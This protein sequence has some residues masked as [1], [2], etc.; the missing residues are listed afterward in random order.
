MFQGGGTGQRIEKIAVKA[1]S[2]L[3][4]DEFGEF[5]F[6]RPSV[7]AD[8]AIEGLKQ[9]RVHYDRPGIQIHVVLAV[10]G[11]QL[12]KVFFTLL[13]KELAHIIIAVIEENTVLF[14]CLHMLLHGDCGGTVIIEIDLQRVKQKKH[15]PGKHKHSFRNPGRHAGHTYYKLIKQRG[16]ISVGQ[17]PWNRGKQ[18]PAGR[19]LGHSLAVSAGMDDENPAALE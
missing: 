2:C 5:L 4:V 3:F 6:I 12:T 19:V 7:R 9:I 11:A 18:L 15:I 14:S 8:Q 1:D 10:N 17:L 13:V 16:G